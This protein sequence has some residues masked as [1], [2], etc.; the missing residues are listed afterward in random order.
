MILFQT[1]HVLEASPPEF[2]DL[3]HRQWRWVLEIKWR[4]VEW[5]QEC[6][7]ESNKTWF[8]AGAYYCLNVSRH[9]KLGR[10]HAYY[11]GPHD[12]FSLGFLHYCWSGDWCQ[13]CHDGE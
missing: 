2:A 11:A 10:S 7:T 1:K 4:G 5:R 12:A 13:K 8:P 6:R 9:F 3:G